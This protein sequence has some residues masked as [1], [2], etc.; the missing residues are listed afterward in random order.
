MFGVANGAA[1]Y[2]SLKAW[3]YYFWGRAKRLFDQMPSPRVCRYLFPL[4]ET[5]TLTSA[6]RPYRSSTYA[7]FQLFSTHATM[8]G[9]LLSP[10][11]PPSSTHQYRLMCSW[12]CPPSRRIATIRL[13]TT[14]ISLPGM[15]A[16]GPL[17]CG[18]SWH[19]KYHR[20][21]YHTIEVW[22]GFAYREWRVECER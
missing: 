11:P 19:L 16:R 7:L 3:P 18:R 2:T 9:R 15:G 22:R 1:R 20:V 5:R 4:I 6:W 12:P 10:W 21:M 13:V 17:Q 8:S 14:L